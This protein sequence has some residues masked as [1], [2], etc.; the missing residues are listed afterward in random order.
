MDASSSTY[1]QVSSYC[2]ILNQSIDVTRIGE[3]C[4]NRIGQSV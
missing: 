3:V 1:V 4:R 2:I